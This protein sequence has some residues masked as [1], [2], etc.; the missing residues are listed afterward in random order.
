MAREPPAATGQPCRWPAAM[1]VSPTAALAGRWNGRKACAATPPK[2]ARAAGDRHSRAV[3]AAGSSACGPK[4]ASRSGWRGTWVSGRMRS[5]ASASKPSASGPN[6]RRHR[7]PSAPPSPSAVSWTDRRSTPASPES[8]G[9]AQSMSGRRQVRPW[10]PR[11]R[12]RRNGEPTAIGWVA[13]QWS[14]RSPGVS[15]LVRVPPPM[16]PAASRTVTSTP[17]R[18]RYT[19]AARPFGPLPTTTAVVMCLPGPSSLPRPVRQRF[20]CVLLRSPALSRRGTSVRRKARHGGAGKERSGPSKGP[21]PGP[22][23][24]SAGRRKDVPAPLALRD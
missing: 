23:H 20:F 14:C 24:R 19:A 1:I 18:A 15:S 6:T 12:L 17:S 2:R 22:V 9:C 3:T 4:A 10:R 13:E 8:S 7:R 11:S 5:S 21:G 16:V